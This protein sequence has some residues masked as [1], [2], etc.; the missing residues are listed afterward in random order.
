MQAW[1]LKHD[2]CNMYSK[3][4]VWEVSFFQFLL[5]VFILLFGIVS[6]KKTGSETLKLPSNNLMWFSPSHGFWYFFQLKLLL[7]FSTVNYEHVHIGGKQ[8]KG[9]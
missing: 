6:Q 4:L 5:N 1:R 8:C 3:V 2:D 9:S 7:L